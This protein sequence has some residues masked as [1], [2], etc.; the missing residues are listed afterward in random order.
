MPSITLTTDIANTQ[1][2]LDATGYPG[3]PV[4]QEEHIKSVITQ[5][6]KGVVKRYEQEQVPDDLSV[7]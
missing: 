1:R 5:F 2:V 3:L 7:T 4:T 6:L